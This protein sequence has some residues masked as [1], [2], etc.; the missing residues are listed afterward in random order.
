MYRSVSE[1]M[2]LCSTI[3]NR[4]FFNKNTK[5]YPL[6]KIF[7]SKSYHRVMQ[8]LFYWSLSVF[9]L[10][11]VFQLLHMPGGNIMLILGGGTLSAWSLFTAWEKADTG[12][13]LR[14]E[15]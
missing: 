4:L 10:G 15:E 1:K 14:D 12:G 9:I 6:K 13:D 7:Q 11:I 2:Y 8:Q 5:M 3:S